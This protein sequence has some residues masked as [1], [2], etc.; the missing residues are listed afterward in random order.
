MLR[1][2]QRFYRARADNHLLLLEPAFESRSVGAP[3]I[4]IEGL[5]HYL[6]NHDIVTYGAVRVFAPLAFRRGARIG[7]KP[8]ETVGQFLLYLAKQR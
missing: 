4:A 1:R 5:G 8:A 7:R 2:S 3:P 6:E